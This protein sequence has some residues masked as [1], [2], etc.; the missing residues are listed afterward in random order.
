MPLMQW[1]FCLQLFTLKKEWRLLPQHHLYQNRSAIIRDQITIKTSNPKCRLYWCRQ[2]IQSVML[3][4]S[5]PLVNKRSSNLLTGSPPPV[6]PFPLWISTGV[7]IFTVCNKGK[8]GSGC[9]ESIYRSC[10]LCISPDSDPS[11]LLYRPREHQTDKHLPPGPL[12]G[13]LL[14][15]PTFRV[16]CL[17]SYLVHGQYYSTASFKEQQPCGHIFESRFEP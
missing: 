14:R 6:P 10:T 8:E 12:T 16:W 7:C 3:V 4:F 1:L 9:L 2:E 11:K 17:Y 5:T 13:Q 15:K